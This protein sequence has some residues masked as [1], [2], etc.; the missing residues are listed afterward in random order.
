LV[1]AQ[2]VGLMPAPHIELRAHSAF[3][4]RDVVD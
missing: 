2:M 3:S 4:F 1:P